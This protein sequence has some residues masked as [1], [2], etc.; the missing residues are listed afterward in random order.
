MKWEKLGQIYDPRDYKLPHGCELYAKSPQALIFDDFVRVYFCSSQ[1]DPLG[2]ILCRILFVDFNKSF[3]KIINHSKREVIPLGVLG[4]FDEHGIFPFGVFKDD[5]GIKAYTTGWSRRLSVSIETS[6][7]YAESTDDGE[8]FVKLG[9]GPIVTSSLHEPFLVCDAFVFKENSK[10]FMFYIF[11]KKWVQDPDNKTN[12][13]VYK[14]SVAQSSDG[15]KWEK[16][17]ECIIADVLNENECQ[18]LPTVIKIGSRYH[19]YFCYREMFGFRTEKGK[20]YKIGYAYSDDLKKWTRDDNWGGM[21]LSESGWDS[22]M[23]C[24]PNIFKLDEKIYMLYNGNHFGRYG[25][26]I[27]EL[28]NL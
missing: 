11:G 27:A 14:I 19:M 26:G 28:I 22:E 20:G 12:E 6:I 24:Y 16:S 4:T 15:I 21:S 9:N 3:T 7:G 1:I 10:Y 25:F 13:R 18:A 23:M 17:S 2:K 8:T 5:N